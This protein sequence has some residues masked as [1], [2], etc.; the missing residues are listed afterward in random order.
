MPP[1]GTPKDENSPPLEG[2]S[3]GLSRMGRPTPEG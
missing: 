2:C 1:G 3:G